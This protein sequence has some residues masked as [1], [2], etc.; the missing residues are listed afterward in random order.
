MGIS[1]LDKDNSF[2]LLAKGYTEILHSVIDSIEINKS[3]SDKKSNLEILIKLF[4]W[5]LENDIQVPERCAKYVGRLIKDGTITHSVKSSKTF[6]NKGYQSTM[7]CLDI[8]NL[9]LQGEALNQAIEHYAKDNHMKPTEIYKYLESHGKIARDMIDMIWDT[10]LTP[11]QL[12]DVD[13]ILIYA[14]SQ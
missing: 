12:L 6:S 7:T 3:V 8:F 9:V 11:E 4:G 1:L 13:S 10:P 14:R 2:E 5:F